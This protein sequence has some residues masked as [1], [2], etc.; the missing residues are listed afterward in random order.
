VEWKIPLLNPSFNPAK[1][2]ISGYITD[3]FML[4][5]VQYIDGLMGARRWMYA[6]EQ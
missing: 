5:H 1:S 3:F 4:R 6:G 2:C